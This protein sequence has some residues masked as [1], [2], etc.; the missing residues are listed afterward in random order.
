MSP[1][2]VTRV[3]FPDLLDCGR[4]SWIGCPIVWCVRDV[5]LCMGAEGPRTRAR[6]G[7]QA[8]PLAGGAQ[9]A[10]PAAA[11]RRLHGRGLRRSRHGTGAGKHPRCRAGTDGRT[12]G[13]SQDA[14]TTRAPLVNG[15]PGVGAPAHSSSAAARATGSASS[16]RPRRGRRW[17]T[18]RAAPRRRRQRTADADDPAT[19]P[20]SA[21]STRTTTA[22]T[23]SARFYLVSRREGGF[24]SASV[25]GRATDA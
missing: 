4:K 9:H 21:G 19:R 5:R 16:N 6:P 14:D 18:W 25:S 11:G 7:R 10:G 23:A 20:R 13:P 15:L 22:S 2:V 3:D 24:E 8:T 17:A 12:H 1:A